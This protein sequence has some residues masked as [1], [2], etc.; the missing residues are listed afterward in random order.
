MPLS[1]S[2]QTYRAVRFID[3][4][5]FW[6]LFLGVL[7]FFR[8]A[9]DL[10]GGVRYIM[11]LPVFGLAWY[12]LLLPTDLIPSPKWALT[13]TRLK[14]CALLFAGCAPMVILWSRN[15]DSFY[16]YLNVAAW[17]FGAA[18]GMLQLSQ[19]MRELCNAVDAHGLAWETRLTYH[20]I[21]WITLIGTWGC[22]TGL[23]IAGSIMGEAS[24]IEI[25]R[26]LHNLQFLPANQMGVS[27][28]TIW[29]AVMLFLSSPIIF[30]FSV[31]FRTRMVLHFY[32]REQLK[33][34]DV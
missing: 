15:T 17:G 22:V 24:P 14:A 11:L 12:S 26:G 5:F 29:V 16:L 20:M 18:M 23:T 21:F 33:G 31:T 3:G 6:L 9:F 25:L 1:Q 30:F 13:V 7:I 27:A 19:I 32:I 10:A 4:I 2:L 28:R 8:L 34:K